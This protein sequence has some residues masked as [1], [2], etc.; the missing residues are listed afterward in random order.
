MENHHAIDLDNMCQ[1][2][3]EFPDRIVQALDIGR[4]INIHNTYDKN[5]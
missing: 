1:S 5:S 2:I 3:Y 4:T